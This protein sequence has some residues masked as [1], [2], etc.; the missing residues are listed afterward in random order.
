MKT[1]ALWVTGLPASGKTTLARRLVDGLVARG[2]RAT[3]VD[4]DEVRG[5]ITPEPTYRDIERQVVYRSMA[6]LARRLSAEGIVPVVAATAHRREFRDWARVICPGVEF[7]FA[8]CDVGRC[9]ARDPKGLYARADRDPANRLPGVGADFETPD[10]A[11]IT[12]DTSRSVQM[13][14]IQGIL[15]RFLPEE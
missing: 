4:S 3:L 7:V 15:D 6:Y 14:V 13:P 2:L 12:V 1:T 8:D 5:H 9:R 10:D 11:E